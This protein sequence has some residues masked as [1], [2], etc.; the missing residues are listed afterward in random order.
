MFW[1]VAVELQE[2]PTMTTFNEL[3][4]GD[5]FLVK[6]SLP[7]NYVSAYWHCLK[8]SHRQ[9]KTLNGKE[10]TIHIDE[11]TIVLKL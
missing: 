4:K 3:A 5:S 8:V 11:M 9:A 6:L 2:R 7:D 10:T 1:I